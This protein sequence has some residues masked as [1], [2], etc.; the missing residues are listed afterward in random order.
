MILGLRN[1]I[2]NV[3]GLGSVNVVNLIIPLLLI[4]ILSR[5]L[6][7][8]EY[9]YIMYVATIQIFLTIF[10]DYSFNITSVKEM[11]QAKKNK[12]CQIFAE[13]QVSR[14]ILGVV[15]LLLLVVYS[16]VIEFNPLDVALFVLPFFLGHLLISPWY[17]QATNN[18]TSMAKVVCAS[19]LLHM[20]I[21][22]HFSSSE[23]IYSITLY[24]QAYSYF[25][26][27]VCICVINY[28]LF[29]E[30]FKYVFLKNG[31][32]EVGK[33]VWKD[34]PLFISDFSPNLYTNIPSIML[35]SLISP[36][37]YFQYNLAT[38][39]IG[40]ALML[41]TTISRAMYPILC[42]NNRFRSSVVLLIN[43]LPATFI[44]I[45]L[46]LYSS[47]MFTLVTNKDDEGFSSYLSIM[48]IGLVFATLANFLG[49]NYLLV[50]TD[51]KHFSKVV[52]ISCLV[53][54]VVGV[55]LVKDFE[56][57]GAAM[58]LTLGRFLYLLG[59]FYSFLFYQKRYLA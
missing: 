6:T 42:D 30:M 56:A 21:V 10:M 51:G 38:K 31:K 15:F 8:D 17:F 49:Q 44:L 37:S 52:T 2:K 26:A 48:S 13:T 55:W 33:R 1:L 53:S 59:C 32:M 47:E 4:P 14:F 57:I 58:L 46:C 29:Y 9:G 18:I 11:I 41:Q 23:E 12:R 3:V 16:V 43:C 19:R 40:V 25:F 45:P 20:L 50:K 34:L 54:G 27:G 36:S 7:A 28:R 24:S 39:F 5:S 22:I 35:I